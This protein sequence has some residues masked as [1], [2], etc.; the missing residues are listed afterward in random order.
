MTGKRCHFFSRLPDLLTSYFCLNH[1]IALLGR[2][3]FCQHDIRVHFRIGD[4]H[5]RL[6]GHPR[7]PDRPRFKFQQKLAF[8]CPVALLHFRSKALSIQL[9]RAKSH[10]NQNVRAAVRMNP[11]RMACRE[12]CCNLTVTGRIQPAVLRAF[13]TVELSMSIK[14]CPKI[15]AIFYIRANRF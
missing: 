2:S 12:K 8:F 9:D 13:Q 4:D 6:Y 15:L 5:R 14:I 7:L 10:M 11:D 1:H 3:L